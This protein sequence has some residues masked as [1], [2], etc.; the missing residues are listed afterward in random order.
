MNTAFA[1]LDTKTGTLARYIRAPKGHILPCIRTDWIKLEPWEQ[2]LSKEIG[3]DAEAIEAFRQTSGVYA[4]PELEPS[5][6]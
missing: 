2:V 6:A 4:S 1:L 3:V 5:A